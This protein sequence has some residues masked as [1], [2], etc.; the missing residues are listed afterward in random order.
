MKLCKSPG[1]TS[2]F[3]GPELQISL[4]SSSFIFAVKFK[5]V[6]CPKVGGTHDRIRTGPI[7]I[8]TIGIKM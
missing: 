4:T 3:M 5:S 6:V 1:Q 2:A 7:K 8:E